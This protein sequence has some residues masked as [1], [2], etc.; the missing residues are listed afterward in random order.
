[1]LPAIFTVAL[2]FVG[3]SF[4]APASLSKRLPGR[5]VQASTTA[6][7]DP[8]GV[9][10]RATWAKDGSLIAGYA[11]TDG[12]QHVLRTARSTDGGLTW[13]HQGEVYRA[14]KTTHDIDN[15]FPLQIPGGRILYAYRNHDRPNGSQYT[16]Y[17]ITISYSD[18]NGATFKYLSTVAQRAA[19]G[20]NGL[21]EPFLRVANDGSLQC[22]YSGENAANDQDGYM[23]QSLDG[24]KT[25]SS[26]ITVSGAGVTSR[27]GMIGVA[28]IDNKGN[29]M[30]VFENTESGFFSIDYVRS[31]DDGKS[32]GE[33]GRLYTAANGGQAIAPQITNVAGTLVASFMTDES[34]GDTGADG[35]QMKVIT[36]TDGGKSWGSSVV[37]GN[38][39]SHWPGL[40]TRDSTHFLALYSKNGLGAV[41]QVYEL[42]N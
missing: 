37:T 29:L 26:P 4:G 3:V 23:R 10:I 39:A 22:Y 1:M 9:Y 31:H 24:G 27:D 19:S 21:W 16:Y 38:V 15:A 30:A 17:R 34:I 25:W 13:A 28:K 11:A 14:D 12:T 36:S 33:R 18:D 20:V 5:V 7:I 40:F 41:S 8:V 42:E 6:V 32:W 2:A 35:G